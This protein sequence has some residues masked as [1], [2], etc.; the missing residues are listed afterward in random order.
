MDASVG[1]E[2]GLE[3]IRSPAPVMLEAAP[4]HDEVSAVGPVEHCRARAHH[5]IVPEGR[6]QVHGSAR[7]WKRLVVER[8]VAAGQAQ[9]YVREHEEAVEGRAIRREIESD[10]KW[11]RVQ[12]IAARDGRGAGLGNL[13]PDEDGARGLVA[14]Y[15]AI[16]GAVRASPPL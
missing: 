13:V 16:T 15:P 1:M 12:V 14:I 7:V 8:V 2:N 5:E 10:R 9:P 6:D 3:G 4:L 11:S